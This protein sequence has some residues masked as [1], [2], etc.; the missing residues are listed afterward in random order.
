MKQQNGEENGLFIILYLNTS[1]QLHRSDWQ[2]Q[3]TFEIMDV[4][5]Q[6]GE[7]NVWDHLERR[8]E[9]VRLKY[10]MFSGSHL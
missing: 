6:I 5:H 10:L 8:P 9:S 2:K 4:N 7:S 1:V 3:C